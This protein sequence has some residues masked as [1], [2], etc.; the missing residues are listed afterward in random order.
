MKKIGI[1]LLIVMFMFL[2]GCKPKEKLTISFETN[3][4]SSIEDV[5][6]DSSLDFD[7]PDDPVK[8]GYTFAGWYLD[9]AFDVEYSTSLLNNNITLYAKWIEDEIVYDLAIFFESNGGN[10]I[11]PV[12]KSAGEIITE[13][14]HPVKEGYEFAGWYS[15]VDLTYVYHFNTMPEESITL[16]A[17]WG[18]LGLEYELI[19]DE[20]EYS[21]NKGNASE[22]TEI[23]IPN[24]KDGK[25]VTQIKNQGF[26]N[27]MNLTK[28]I[29]PKTIVLIPEA[30]FKGCGNLVEM[31]LP[32]TGNNRE[33]TGYQGLFGYIFG[34]EEFNGSKKVMQYFMELTSNDDNNNNSIRL[35][36][37]PLLSFEPPTMNCFYI[38]KCLNKIVITDEDIIKAG[39]F[40]GLINLDSLVLN[41]GIT[42]ISKNAFSGCGVKGIEN[43]KSVIEID[44]LGLSG[45]EVIF[46]EGIN[47]KTIKSLSFYSYA[48]N[49][50]TIPNSVIKIEE[51][52][53]YGS[54]LKSV[55]I[56]NSVEEIEKWVFAHCNLTIYVEAINKPEGWDEDWNLENRPVVWGYTEE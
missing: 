24:I 49:E 10:E 47:L 55:Y 37:K 31:I 32:F 18:T 17:D 20:T 48:G 53:F 19:N 3:G 12:I 45:A 51:T 21:V 52:A 28:I 26:L 39:A 7:L 46:K 35:S 9:E 42:K 2:Y 23:Q 25:K 43:P 14:T 4:G 41:E 22:L 50:L 33:A 38:S 40:S 5:V 30:S 27:C 36:I 56:P 1:V 29:I 44:S 15:D 13:P 6:I 8:E 11:E 54:S 16:Y 34:S